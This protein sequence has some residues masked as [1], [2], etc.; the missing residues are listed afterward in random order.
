MRRRNYGGNYLVARPFSFIFRGNNFFPFVFLKSSFL[1]CLGL[2]HQRCP[3]MA[4]WPTGPS[5]SESMSDSQ[6]FP[7]PYSRFPRGEKIWLSPVLDGLAACPLSSLG[8]GQSQHGFR[9]QRTEMRSGGRANQWPFLSSNPK[10]ENTF[11]LK[12]HVSIMN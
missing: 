4:P 5:I 8:R 10:I 7:W 1:C 11:F 9:A 6:D 2:A 3:P 12:N